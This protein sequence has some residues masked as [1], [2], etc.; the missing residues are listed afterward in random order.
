MGTARQRRKRTNVKHKGFKKSRST[1]RR[2]KDLDQIQDE[3]KAASA[4][5]TA[6]PLPIDPD[7]PGLGQFYC[8][9]CARYFMDSENLE[10]HNKSRPHKRRVKL[11]LEE[12][13]TQEE[14]DR[15]AGMGAPDNGKPRGFAPVP[16]AAS[17]LASSSSSSSS[18]AAAAAA[19]PVSS[20]V[21]MN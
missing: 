10:K 13:Y 15:G 3:I 14:A 16:I 4:P 6:K 11:T 18:S 12:K 8:M 2:A 17:S 9:A 1:A 5:E 21:T 20:D 19:A 7:L